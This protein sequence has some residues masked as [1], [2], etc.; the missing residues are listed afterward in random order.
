MQE[1]PTRLTPE[2]EAD[3][4]RYY[5]ERCL[6]YLRR[7]IYEHLLS[8]KDTTDYFELNTFATEHKLR[9]DE[10]NQMSEKAAVELNKLGWQTGFGFGHTGL[11]VYADAADPPSNL[12]PDGFD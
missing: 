6:C 5:L 9:E 11:F 3:F 10:V 7:D 2:K 12:Y 1:F 4:R 8:R